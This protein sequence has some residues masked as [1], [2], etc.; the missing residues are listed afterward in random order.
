MTVA[1]SRWRANSDEDHIC[2]ADRATKFGCKRQATRFH[3]L[4]DQ[5]VKTW[6]E[7]RDFA[8]LK[9]VD[10]FVC[11]VYTDHVVTEIRKT[12]TG[13]KSNVS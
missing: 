12:G 11:F 8:M 1:S 4:S 6:F 7:D 9:G 2:I 10:F 3:V 5:S 13:N